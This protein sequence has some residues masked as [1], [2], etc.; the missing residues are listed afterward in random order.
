[1]KKLYFIMAFVLMFG[2][3]NPAY[4]ADIYVAPSD[5][6]Q[7][8]W[9]A[10]PVAERVTE[11]LI[12]I[13]VG[14]GGTWT[15][16]DTIVTDPATPTLI[17]NYTVSASMGEYFFYVQPKNIVDVG[18]QSNIVSVEVLGKPSPLQLF[19]SKLVAWLKG[20][21]GGLTVRTV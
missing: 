5:Q 20:I 1:M 19:I 21:F 10:P 18:D 12:Y 14:T 11:V 7:F 3:F 17:Y 9:L 15:L 16:T 13:R 2:I 6:I 8:N 4:S